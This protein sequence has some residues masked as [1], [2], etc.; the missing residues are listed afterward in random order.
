[1][2]GSQ[3][4]QHVR[5]YGCPDLIPLTGEPTSSHIEYLDLLQNRSSS[6]LLPE[7]VAEFQGSPVLYLVGD[8]A[9]QAACNRDSDAVRKLQKLL[10]NRNEQA[11]LG[12]V[13]PGSLDI[14]PIN[15]DRKQL[16]KATP[17]VIQQSATDAPTFFQS[18]AGEPFR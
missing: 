4:A 6:V 15:L 18:L 1:M 3:L 2:N 8:T 16:E 12:I 14:Y 7:A 11:C 5:A 9:A 13:R 17:L 10:A